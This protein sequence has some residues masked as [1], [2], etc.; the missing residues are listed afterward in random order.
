[1]QD[2]TIHH[3]GLTYSAR[4]R[5]GRDVSQSAGP[6]GDRVWD[7]THMGATVTSFPV[8]DDD[9][10]ASVSEKVVEWLDANAD[11]PEQDVGRQ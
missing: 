7:V 2:I 5:D 6:S 8:S 4:I 10:K 11:R 3:N 9:T 1:M